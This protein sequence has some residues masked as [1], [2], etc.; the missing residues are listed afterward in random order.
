VRRRTMLTERFRRL[1]D[2]ES[3][4]PLVVSC[5]LDTSGRRRPRQPDLLRAADQVVRSVRAGADRLDLDREERCAVEADL[6]DFLRAV[7]GL[8]DRGPTRGLI[9]FSCRSLGLAEQ[10]RLPVPLGDHGAI[11]RR[12][13]LLPLESALT[14][15]APLGLVLT[16]RERTRIAMQQLGELEELDEVLDEVPAQSS[17]GG[18]AQARLARHAAAAAHHHAKRSAEAAY[19]AFRGVQGLELVLAGP[20]SAVKDLA[21]SLRSELAERVVAELRLPVGASPLELARA[22]SEV[23]AKRATARNAALVRRVT[24]HASS[25]TVAAGLGAVIE[26]LRQRRLATVLATDRMTSP[27]ANC[28]SC[29]QLALA[30]ECPSCGTATDALDDV[31]EPALE[32]AMRQGATV[33]VVPD[34]ALETI[35]GVG[36]VLRY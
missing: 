18:W 9:S 3:D 4:R 28:P 23:A 10:L 17:G 2:V 24:E 5:Y 31:V 1:R 25:P 8:V 27:G 11:G 34:S 15:D 33:V 20:E 32:E 7:G 30:L 29:G 26:A 12:P 14:G 19:H 36:A 6:D 35:G 13:L 16:D 21:G 22:L